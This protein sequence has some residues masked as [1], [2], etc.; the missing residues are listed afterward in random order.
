VR[1]FVLD[2]RAALFLLIFFVHMSWWTA[3]I[4]VLATLVFGFAH[5]L[6]WPLPMVWR[7]VR[8]F[9]AGRVRPARHKRRLYL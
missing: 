6:R 8:R 1:F 5:Y 2:G 3:L 7:R 4:A 9:L